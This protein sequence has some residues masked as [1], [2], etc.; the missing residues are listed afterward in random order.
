[1]ATQ[2]R[3]WAWAGVLPDAR[4]WVAESDDPAARCALLT[5]VDDVPPDDPAVIAARRVMLADP[6]T[7]DLLARLTPWDGGAP[8]SGHN[9]PAFAPNLLTLLADRGLRPGDDPR[10]DGV[11]DAMLE[12]QAEDGRFETFA[13]PRGGEA[14]AWGALPCD[15][16]A[17]VEILLRYGRGTDPRV[18]RAVTALG[19]GLTTTAQG[20]AWLCIPHTVTGFRGPGRRGDMC[21]QVTLEALRAFSYVDPAERPATLPGAVR[22]ALGVWRHREDA[23]PYMFGHGKTFKTSKWPVTWYGAQA[24]VDAV[25]RYPEVWTDDAEDRR[26]VAEITACLIAYNTD[27]AGRVVPRSTFRGFEDHSF[28]Q[29]KAPSAFATALLLTVLRRVEDLAADV[30]A[31]DV[32]AL[33]S[34]KGGTGVALP[35]PMLRPGVPTSASHGPQLQPQD[36]TSAPAHRSARRATADVT[37]GEEGS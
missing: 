20:L 11:L 17:V 22:S 36:Q 5:G 34:S 4:G 29:K 8:L 31:V 2:G 25:G 33:P 16:N 1:M 18:G 13:A 26:A 3:A 28:G 21:P 19:A 14:P 24:V 15:N 35:P 32:R 37:A 30:R 27:D 12:H 23:K 6:A 10:V 9:Q 7:A